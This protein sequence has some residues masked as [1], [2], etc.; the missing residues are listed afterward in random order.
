MR[1]ADIALLRCPATREPLHLEPGAVVDG[2]DVASGWLSTADGRHRYPIVEH[3]PRFVGSENYATSFGLQWNHFRATQLDSHSGQPISRKRFF[4]FS[5]WEA[6]ELVGKTIL[7]VGCGAGRFTEIALAAGAQVVAMD[8]SSAVDACWVKNRGKGPLTVVQ[9]DLYAM[10]FSDAAFDYVYCFGVLQHTPDVA[11]AVHAL[12]APLRNGGKLAVDLYPRLARNVL[13]PKYWLRPLTSR[14]PPD[15]LFRVVQRIGPVLLPISLAIGRIPVIG[16][17]LRYAI[18]VVNY[19]GVYPLTPVQL[20]EWAVLDTF[21]MLAPRHDH[22]QTPATLRRWLSELGL[23]DVWV[24]R[25]GFVVGRARR[26]L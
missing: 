7:D 26:G 20:R 6:R 22:P 14:L 25:R 19:E 23:V 16:K 2:D 1:S 13:W 10:P 5:G 9:G 21:D 11:A 3:V 18:P 17:Q 8:Y 4:A 24:E 15:V 12:A